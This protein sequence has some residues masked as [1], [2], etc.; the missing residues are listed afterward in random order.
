MPLGARPRGGTGFCD[1][2]R[3]RHV[4]GALTALETRHRDRAIL[5]DLPVYDQSASS[6]MVKIILCI[7]RIMGSDR[8]PS[9]VSGPSVA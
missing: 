5:Y 8:R 2:C 1:L 3:D 9:F 6:L 7:S 4:A